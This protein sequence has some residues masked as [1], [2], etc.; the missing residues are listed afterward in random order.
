MKFPSVLAALI[1]SCGLPLAGAAEPAPFTPPK[2]VVTILVD[3]L[4]YDYLDRFRD[5][6]PAGGF[7]MFTEQGAFMTFAQYDYAPTVTGP[8]HA[9]FL[10][11]APPSV[12]GII[13]ND[14]FD[15]RA[16]KKINCVSDPSVEG[17][18][19]VVKDGG[20]ASAN[21]QRSPR[22]FV[23]S[24]FSDEMRLRYQSKVVGVAIKDRGAILPAGKKP[25]GAYWFDSPSGNFITSTYYT[26]ELPAWVAAFNAR[27]LPESYI[28]QTWK[29]LL[30]PSRYHWPDQAAGEANFPGEKTPTFDHVVRQSPTEGFENVVFTPFGNQLLTDFALA[31]IEGEKLGAGSQTDVL[32][33]SYSSTDLCGHRF[34]PYSQEIQDMILRLDRDLA[35]LFAELDK[36][37]GLKNVAMILTADHGVAPTA[38]FA[39][40]QG[41]DGVRTDMSPHFAEL[42][43]Q[44]V[45][46]F[47]EGK[48]FLTPRPTDNQFYFDYPALRE[49]KVDSEQLAVFLRDWAYETGEYQ[50][51]YT[52]TQLLEGR[53]PG[54]LGQRVINGFHAERSGDVVLI[55]KPFH[56]PNSYKNG[57]THGSPYS[58][59]A[60]IPIAFYGAAFKPGRYADEFYI[61][62]IAATLCSALH[63]TVPSGSIGKPCV[64]ILAEHP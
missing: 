35:R 27:K 18:G 28:G 40:E 49:R 60:H 43:K 48:F 14:W 50:A 36:K 7:K 51:A 34:G 56:L 24:N 45:A 21:G 46:Q 62:D 38:D 58:Y 37:F 57:T 3:Q 61:T 41:L 1:I 4:R 17:V 15:K 59:D 39:V 64:E 44:L 47:G 63:V 30:E 32:S 5:Q 12:H 52:R 25:T 54:M 13:Q 8:G 23:G 20:V 53:A 11:G 22:N 16:G 55:P 9:S 31:A 29:R 26:K 6:F 33:I 10:S 42:D 19:L 2:L